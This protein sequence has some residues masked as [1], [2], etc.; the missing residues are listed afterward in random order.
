MESAPIHSGKKK[1]P[2]VLK[3][4]ELIRGDEN[5]N[6]IKKKQRRQRLNWLHEIRRYQ[7]TSELLL[8][9]LPFYRL[10]KEITHEVSTDELRYSSQA[11]AALQ[12]A[13]EAFLVG[14]MED[15]QYCTFHAKRITLMKQDLQLA[16]R[17]RKK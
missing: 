15:A 7:K 11:L 1:R 13:C 8:R 16:L 14:L 12:E 4:P 17:I 10:V 6:D 9:K 3:R 5:K 2:A